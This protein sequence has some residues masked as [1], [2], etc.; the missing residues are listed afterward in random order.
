[1][2]RL[3]LSSI[4]L[5][6]S[7]SVVFNDEKWID[8]RTC[9]TAQEVK[10]K[11]I[12]D[13]LSYCRRKTTSH[14]Y[15][16]RKLKGSDF[17]PCFLQKDFLNNYFKAT[18]GFIPKSSSHFVKEYIQ[19][20]LYIIELVKDFSLWQDGIMNKKILNWQGEMVMKFDESQLHRV[21]EDLSKVLGKFKAIRPIERSLYRY[22]IFV[23][24]I[25]DQR[26]L[27][28]IGK[29]I[30]YW[31][32]ADN[33]EVMGGISNIQNSVSLIK[34]LRKDNWDIILL[35]D[36]NDVWK[37]K[38]MN[39]LIKPKVLSRNNIFYF[40]KSL[41]DS[42]PAAI[43]YKAFVKL[44]IKTEL[45]VKEDFFREK[46]RDAVVSKLQKT[47]IKK[48]IDFKDKHKEKYNQLLMQE[49]LDDLSGCELLEMLKV[50][51]K[52]IEKDKRQFYQSN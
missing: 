50:L 20:L 18:V 22:K 34:Q 42:Y 41:E 3:R 11:I 37:R 27:T 16:L 47:L 43:Q 7:E 48:G 46:N 12:H 19:Y 8:F 15:C 17:E 28:E 29:E 13:A 23:E 21:N 40:K 32:F 39:L 1:M 33:I 6:T 31:F 52:K 35:L 38:V 24:G 5:N 26:A 49:Y 51:S 44:E 9:S 25:D 45:D 14:A 10:D 4:K 2:K 30:Q 36:S